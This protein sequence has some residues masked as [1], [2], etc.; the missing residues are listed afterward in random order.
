MVGDIRTNGSLLKWTL[1]WTSH[2][3]LSAMALDKESE[4]QVQI[5]GGFESSNIFNVKEI[6]KNHFEVM[7]RPDEPSDYD[8]P[9]HMFYWFY[10]KIAGAKDQTITIDITNAEWMPSHWD[11]YTP[12]YTYASDPNGLTEH[13]WE[14]IT[15]TTRFFTTFS[16]THTFTSDTV[17]VALRYP[18]TYTYGQ[19]YT[20][21][22]RNNPFVTVETIGKTREGRNI[23]LIIITDKGVKNKDKKGIWLVAKDHAVEQDGAWMIEGIIEFLLSKDTVAEILRK[24]TIFAMVPLAAPDA[25][26]HGRTVNPITGADVSHSYSIGPL[27]IK[28]A[29][30]MTEETKAIWNMV[31]KWVKEG[32]S[33]D[34]AAILH[35][36]HGSEE[37]VWGMF[38]SSHKPEEHKSFHRAFLN[39]LNGY[40]TRTNIFPKLHHTD[41]FSDKAA[42]EF[43]S[44]AFIYEINMH[45]K[46]S[47]LTIN[48]LHKIGEAFARGVFDYFNFSTS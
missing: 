27:S 19:R 38:S 23:D 24:K 3:F 46:G 20:E 37:N 10:L 7:M 33:V 16:F 32:H 30:I 29:E 47:F 31:Q 21:S 36:P 22:I 34:I 28:R 18:Y 4:S 5:I 1:H 8:Y 13:K 12:V 11:N 26:Y 44:L 25:T 42:S 14:R 43:N 45:A 40:T 39:N 35:N 2:H 48:D 15:N 6:S 41:T 17:W 9:D